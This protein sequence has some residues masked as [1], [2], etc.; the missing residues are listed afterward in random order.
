[1]GTKQFDNYADLITF[2]RASGATYLD[3]DGVLKTASTNTPRIEYDA[4][5]NR[6]GLLVEGQ[7]TNLVTYSEDFS[8]AAW[9]HPDATVT[10]NDTTAPDGTTTAEKY[11]ST[12]I[13]RINQLVSL[14][15][16]TVVTYSIFVKYV[17]VQWIR[18]A[19]WSGSGGGNQIRAWFDVQNGVK[20]TENTAFNANT[21]SASIQSAG[22]GWYRLSVTGNFTD[23]TTTYYPSIT[24]A[25]ADAS[26]IREVGSFYLWGAQLEEGAFPT[27]YIP[28]S[29]STATRAADVASIPTSAFGYNASEG[30][31]VCEAQ[32]KDIASN[33]RLYSI[34]DGTDTINNAIYSIAGTA[35]HFV[36]RVNSVT[37][38]TF[39]F[40]TYANGVFGKIAGA[41]KI[42]DVAASL[43]ASTV[44]TDT[45]ALLPTV[46]RM[47][48]GNGFAT[49]YLNGHIK[50]I[51]YYP[52]RLT[53]AQ[54]QELTQ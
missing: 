31:V 11:T 21:I 34:D 47:R 29:G 13:D 44:Q 48:I 19:V 27:S 51:K 2:T 39:D 4:D 9:D 8:N 37:E 38:A 36:V 15:S 1:M 49:N 54:L 52:R 53:N 20:G 24:T 17:D 28:T 33:G 25:D 23:G 16:G 5:G 7:R 43:D 40:G 3:S 45:S 22:N 6:L 32:T 41:Y 10:A 14:A 46:T 30:T 18:V 50:S 35:S 42:N 26:T 12:G